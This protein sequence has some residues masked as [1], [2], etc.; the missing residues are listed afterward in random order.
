MVIC[1][2][3]DFLESLAT[4]LTYQIIVEDECAALRVGIIQFGW[5]HLT[6]G[7]T[8]LSLDC[9]CA[10]SSTPVNISR[11]NYFDLNLSVVPGSIHLL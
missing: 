7:T 5:G 6:N 2:S 1:A 8:R 10:F 4:G 11:T 3:R 9:Q